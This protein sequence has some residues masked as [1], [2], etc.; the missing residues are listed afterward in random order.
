MVIIVNPV[1]HWFTIWGIYWFF[2]GSI[3]IM[4][5]MIGGYYAEAYIIPI[6]MILIGVGSLYYGRGWMNELQ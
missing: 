2:F 6:G 3:S 4:T 5:I 1:K